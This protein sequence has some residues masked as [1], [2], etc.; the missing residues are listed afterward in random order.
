[1]RKVR[2][3]SSV[4][5]KHIGIGKDGY[6][7]DTGMEM[8]TCELRAGSFNRMEA[9][10]DSLQFTPILPSTLL[11]MIVPFLKGRKSTDCTGGQCTQL[12][13]T[14]SSVSTMSNLK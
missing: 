12:S 8:L 4:R 9:T 3:D 11:V 7:P 6:E 5:A 13:T 2:N 1:M 10:P 14:A